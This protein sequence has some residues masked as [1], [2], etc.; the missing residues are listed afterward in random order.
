MQ[1]GVDPCVKIKFGKICH[2]YDQIGLDLA[3]SGPDL[4]RFDRLWTKYERFWTRSEFVRVNATARD[5][6]VNDDFYIKM[7]LGTQLCEIRKSE[8]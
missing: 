6:K 7:P 3:G 1:L 2:R 8:S 5:F 4:T